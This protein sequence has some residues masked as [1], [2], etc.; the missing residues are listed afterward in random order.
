M[1]KEQSDFGWD[2]A[3]KISPAGI[4]QP[5]RVVQLGNASPIHIRNTNIDIFRQGQLNNIPPDQSQPWIFN[6]SIDFL[7]SIPQN[8]A[9]HLT[10]E[11]ADGLKVLDEFLEGVY[12]SDETITGTIL[13]DSNLVDLWYPSGLGSQPLYNAHLCVVSGNSDLAR[14]QRRVGFRTI[15][16]NLLPITEEQQSLGIAPGS[17]FHFEVNGHQFY[18]KGSNLVPPD[19]FW[20][21]VNETTV[22]KYASIQSCVFGPLET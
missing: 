17:N 1:R 2:L 7:G 19:V 12:H 22:R 20:P 3:P 11:D 13:V 10:L 8:A 16:L 6:A 5:A 18:A 14:V 21:R 9:I 15:V 4:W